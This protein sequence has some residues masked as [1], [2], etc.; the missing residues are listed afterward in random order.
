MK[1]LREDENAKAA[2]GKGL[3]P[4]QANGV[5]IRQNGGNT[6]GIQHAAHH[7]SFGPAVGDVGDNNCCFVVLA[8]TRRSTIIFLISA[9]ALA[10]L[11]PFGQALAQFMM[12][13]QR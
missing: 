3:I 10:G 1:I 9:I 13:W 6:G 11:R 12:V 7:F 2:E 4:Q 8:H 5:S